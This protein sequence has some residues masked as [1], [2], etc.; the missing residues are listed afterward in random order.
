MNQFSL[1]GRLSYSAHMLLYPTL[2]LGWVFIVK[3]YNKRSADKIEQ[4]EWDKMPETTKM[5]RELFNP[6]TPIP[7]HNNDELKYSLA[8]INMHGYLNENHLHVKDYPYKQYHNSYSPHNSNTHEY[9]WGS[10]SEP[11]A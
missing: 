11:L 8:H 10:M 9:N 6:F 2:A 1:F 5:D 4:G 3:P 7:Y